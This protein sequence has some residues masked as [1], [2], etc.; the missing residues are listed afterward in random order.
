MARRIAQ[1]RPGRNGKSGG[2]PRKGNPASKPSQCGFEHWGWIP[3]AMIQALL[4]AELGRDAYRCLMRI[5]QEHIGQGGAANGELICTYSDFEAARVPRS[6]I[7]GA[8]A[9]LERG[10]F[11][12]IRRMGRIAGQNRPNLFRVTWMGAW[13]EE[14]L[15]TIPPSNEWKALLSADAPPS[16]RF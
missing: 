5:W 1:T 15:A 13:D 16:G 14:G 10:G 4:N 7:K 8:L 2:R 11:V 12:R 6:R 3:D 9:E